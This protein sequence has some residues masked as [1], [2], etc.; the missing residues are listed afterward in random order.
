MIA[1]S[2]LAR[3]VSRG[4]S[5][6]Y[7]VYAPVKREQKVYMEETVDGS[8][9]ELD[10]V[11]TVNGV[12]DI[13]LPRCEAL[14]RFRVDEISVQP[15]E[16]PAGKRLIFGGRPCDAASLV[17]LDPI[18]MDP[19]RDSRY[20]RKRE[21]TTIV[22]VACSRADGACFCESMGYGP[23]DE[24]GSDVIFLPS[25]DS[26]LVRALSDKGRALLSE[27]GLEADAGGEPDAPPQL[28]R[29]V[30]TEGLKDW[31][32]RNFESEKWRDVSINCISCGTCYYLCPTCHC[33]D[34][35]DEAGVSKGERYRIWD[36]C[37]FSGFTQMAGHQPRVGR[38]ARYRQRIMH[39]FKYTVDNVDL[40]AC[41]GDGRCIR[42]CPVGVDI[43]EILEKLPAEG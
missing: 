37:S 18:L 4:V 7:R 22:T 24:T 35:T 20:A 14:A 26:Y 21:E 23:H 34:I 41:V 19:V 11:V 40:V 9:L 2:D 15:I 8:A 3:L 27:L 38:H 29:K 32:D 10:H 43:G 36:C 16:E 28:T 42:H 5:A 17:I 25:G 33:F 31:L 6:G 39:K 12:K 1:K 13:M 30:S